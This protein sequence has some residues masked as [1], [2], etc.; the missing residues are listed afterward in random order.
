MGFLTTLTI[1]NDGIHLLEPNA[2]EF[3]QEV[4]R[5][6]SGL[7]GPADVALGG[8]VNAVR[9][10]M[11]RHADH[12]TVYVHAGNCLTEMSPYSDST[13]KLLQRN[14]EFFE[15]LLGIMTRNTRMLKEMYNEHKEKQ[16]QA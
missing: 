8:F 6:A 4:C 14:P 12:H 7:H 16:E 5:L 11:S 2:Q 9:V 3:A 10:Q 13:Q 15:K 1:Y